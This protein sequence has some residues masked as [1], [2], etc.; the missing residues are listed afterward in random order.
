MLDANA[1]DAPFGPLFVVDSVAAFHATRP[2]TLTVIEEI[3]EIPGGFM[4]TYQDPGGGHPLCHGPVD[5]LRRSLAATSHGRAPSAFRWLSANQQGNLDLFG[6][7]SSVI[8][9]QPPVEWPRQQQPAG[10][11][12]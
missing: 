9:D 3:S 12:H 4:A 7:E 8:A 6:F 11:G 2:K 1:P 10:G 5:R